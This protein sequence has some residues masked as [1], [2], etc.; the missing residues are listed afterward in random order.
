L[1]DERRTLILSLMKTTTTG[2]KKTAAKREAA[3]SKMWSDARYLRL[4]EKKD[5]ALRADR[6]AD[7]YKLPA[8]QKTQLARMATRAIRAVTKFEDLF[9]KAQG[10]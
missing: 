9:L 7:F 5:A 2:G 8:E 6:L 4:H 1:T 10:C 3:F